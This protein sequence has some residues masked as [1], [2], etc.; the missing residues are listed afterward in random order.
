MRLRSPKEG[1]HLDVVNEAGVNTQLW[2]KIGWDAFVD[3]FRCAR[4]AGPDLLLA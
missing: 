1:L 4:L 3:V 2:D